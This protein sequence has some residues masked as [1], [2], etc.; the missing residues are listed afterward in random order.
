L[1]LILISS[2]IQI[3]ILSPT[4]KVWLFTLCS[5]WKIIVVERRDPLQGYERTQSVYLIE[6]EITV[7]LSKK[8]EIFW[9][10]VK[11]SFSHDTI[12]IKS[13]NIFYK[14]II[15][16]LTQ[17]RAF[18]TYKQESSIIIWIQGIF[19]IIIRLQDMLW[20]KKQKKWT[21]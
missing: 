10:M 13:K 17:N 5:N 8:K 20:L 16:G 14:I 18:L 1:N 15:R 12:Y 21:L 7:W 6:M 19:L 4:G 3:P 9:N 2:W 11:W